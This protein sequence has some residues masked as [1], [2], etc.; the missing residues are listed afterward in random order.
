MNPKMTETALRLVVTTYAEAEADIQIVRRT[1]F[2]DEQG[3]DPAIDWD[4]LDAT[5]T[6]LMAYWHDR[7]VGTMRIRYLNETLAKI[8][9]VAVLADYRG[10]GIGRAL[11]QQAIELLDRQQIPQIKLNAQLQVQDFY[12]KLGFQ[13]WGDVFDEA[14]ISHLEMRRMHC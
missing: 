11:V 8:E 1:V 6:H 9:R 2:Q 14:G 3:V 10:Y 12:Q 13:P 7:P 4:G 5:A